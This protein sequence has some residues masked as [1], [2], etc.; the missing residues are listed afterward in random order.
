MNHVSHDKNFHDIKMVSL[1]VRRIIH[2]REIPVSIPLLHGFIMCQFSIIETTEY[3][4]IFFFIITINISGNWKRVTIYH[5]SIV[6]ILLSI[7][8]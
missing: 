1:S 2:A 4:V 3:V 6:I 7:S 8:T 5:L